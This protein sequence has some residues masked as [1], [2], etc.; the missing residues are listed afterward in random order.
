M[1]IKK[2]AIKN[3]IVRHIGKIA[4]TKSGYTKEL[5]LVAW[6]ENE[7]KYDIRDWSEDHARSSKG[8]TLTAEELKEL[9]LLIDKEVENL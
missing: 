1:A 4:L 2:D 5:N 9:K 7:P 3:V 6:N 8:I